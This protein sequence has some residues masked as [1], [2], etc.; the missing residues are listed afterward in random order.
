MVFIR[1]ADVVS[2]AASGGLQTGLD[3]QIIERAALEF[4]ASSQNPLTVEQVLRGHRSLL[5]EQRMTCSSEDGSRV[6]VQDD[7]LRSGSP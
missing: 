5:R 7:E 2:I 3:E 1:T 4:L 6:M